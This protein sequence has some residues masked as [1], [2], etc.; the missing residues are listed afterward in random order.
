MISSSEIK[1]LQ[2]RVAVYE[3]AAAYK[4]LFLFFN[5]PLRQFAFSFVKSRELAEEIVS[6]VF[7]RIWEKRKDLESVENLKVYLYISI[8]NTALKYLLQL[9]K[10]PSLS[11]DDL[12]VE[13]E[14][15]YRNPEELFLTAE[16][17]RRIED[18]VNALPPRCKLVFKLVK[19]DRLRYKE[20]ADILNIS[21]KTIDAQLALALKKISKAISFDLKVKS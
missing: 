6:D 20:V 18:A 17:L 8:K 4:D 2:R 16:M 19:E 1:E 7:I 14:S 15:F 5:K 11:I 3:D 13:V 21:V 12:D 10:Q 9:K